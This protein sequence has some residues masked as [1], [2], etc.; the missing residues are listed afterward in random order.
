MKRNNS[1]TIEAE[2]VFAADVYRDRAAINRKAQQVLASG[3][4]QITI[5]LGNNELALARRQAE[6]KGLKYQTYIKMLLHQALTRNS[7]AR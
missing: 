6:A 1:K 7:A 2:A 3:S 4:R 5:R